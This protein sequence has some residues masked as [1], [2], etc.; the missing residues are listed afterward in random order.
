VRCARL[1][2]ARA[3]LASEGGRSPPPL[4][5]GQRPSKPRPRPTLAFVSLRRSSAIR[6]RTT[7]NGDVRF[8]KSPP[9]VEPRW[10]SPLTRLEVA[11]GP[12][13]LVLPVTGPPAN[14]NRCGAAEHQRGGKAADTARLPVQVKGPPGPRRAPGAR[15]SGIRL[16]SVPRPD[17]ACT[18]IALKDL[19]R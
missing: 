15:P 12:P 5:L 17:P 19:A 18:Q 3:S 6:E 1:P 8:G 9:G 16:R 7:W 4:G 2:R 10:S 11:L 14:R 13:S